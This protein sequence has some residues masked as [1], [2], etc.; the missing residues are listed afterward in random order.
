[1]VPDP[2]RFHVGLAVLCCMGQLF[3]GSL[4]AGGPV[5]GGATQPDLAGTAGAAPVAA[6]ANRGG[7]A[8]SSRRTIGSPWVTPL[9]IDFGPVGVG[10]TSA[11]LTATITNTGSTVLDGF[12]GG[13]VG[14]PFSAGQ[15]CAGGVAP[16]GSCQY[17]FS[18]SPTAVGAFSATSATTTSAGPFSIELLGEG[19][20]ARVHAEALSLDFGS[21][22]AGSSA[23]VQSVTIHNTGAAILEGF[24]GGGVGPPFTA[25]QSCAGG[26]A[27]GDSCEYFFGFS[28]LA[29]GPYTA[30]SATS[31]NAGTFS[32]DLQ[33]S[34]RSTF[35]AYGQR[36]S[37]RSF[38]FGPVA[39]G[40]S[41]DVLVTEVTNQNPL[42]AITDWAGGGVGAPFSA[43]QNCAPELDPSETCEL[44]YS[45]SPTG[46]GVFTATSTVSNSAGSVSIELRGEGVGADLSV[47]PLVLDFGP[48]PV[49]TSGTSQ[50][51]TVRNTGVATLDGFS[52]G[53]VSAPFSGSQSCAS[54]VAPGDTCQF[55]FNFHPTE[56]GLFTATSNVGT[57][58]GGFTIELIGGMDPTIF[59]DGFESG[60]AGAW[61]A[62]IPTTTG[63]PS[64]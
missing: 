62:S 28:P 6:R 55:F 57:N 42:I 15:N 34:G 25:S 59:D 35:F 27:P 16:G 11:V 56:E 52:G 21:V 17:F 24:A 58:A 40:A 63:R 33:G 7:T 26:V 3:G 51:V 23:E 43:A 18:F 20:G 1:M 9:R 39:V 32:I 12:A 61:T 36:V 10:S 14:A 31:T 64:G 53:G 54:G 44:F 47:T 2:R 13:G 4:A 45:F 48:V 49:G 38:D 8:G 41:A 60:D 50:V 19:I 46:V 37:P 30:T 5:G 22:Y 29:S